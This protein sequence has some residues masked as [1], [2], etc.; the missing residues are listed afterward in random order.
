M[1]AQYGIDKT[2]REQ[3][4]AEGA[5][6]RAERR[7]FVGGDPV[8]DWM[9]A[10]QEVDAELGR[11][12]HGRWLDELEAR[13][14]TVG[15]KLKA[16]RKKASGLGAEARKEIEQDVQKLARLRDAFEKRL[17]EIRAQSMQAGQRA[18]EH[19]EALWSEISAIID[20][21]A[22]RSRKKQ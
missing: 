20:R 11:R 14:E 6:F 13:L 17:E 4:I 16:L 1:E 21:K 19:A 3:R 2:E 9:D 8:A 22:K 12:E 7:G 5:Y 15:E 10:E 18:K